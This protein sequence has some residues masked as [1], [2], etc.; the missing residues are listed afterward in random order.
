MT[1]FHD[2]CFVPIVG[3]TKFATRACH[4][5]GVRS[6]PQFTDGSACCR[7][8][9]APRH[10]S[11]LNRCGRFGD[12]YPVAG[13]CPLWPR[14]DVLSAYSDG[15]GRP[16]SRSSRAS[17]ATKCFS[18]RRCSVP[19]LANRSCGIRPSSRMRTSGRVASRSESGVQVALYD[20]R[21]RGERHSLLHPS[22][23][24]FANALTGCGPVEP[25]EAT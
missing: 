23:S 15:P 6:K 7:R 19:V 24:T 4:C 2:S 5:G 8:E 18:A 12:L 16:R 20:S 21:E 9:S 1:H 25:E 10:P 17:T 11:Q 13:P 14:L 22:V 3:R